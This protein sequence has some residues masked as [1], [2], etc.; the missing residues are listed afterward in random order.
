MS[1]E[2]FGMNFS[3]WLPTDK[4]NMGVFVLKSSTIGKHSRVHRF[5]IGL[6]SVLLNAITILFLG[7]AVI[8]TNQD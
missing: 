2:T 1:T 4:R 6:L 3:F 5:L 8:L 7:H